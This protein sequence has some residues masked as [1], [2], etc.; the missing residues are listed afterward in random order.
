M[1]ET[2]PYPEHLARELAD[3]RRRLARAEADKARAEAALQQS[4]AR[5][6]AFLDNSP[7]VAL[8]KDPEGRLV[9]G[10]AGLDRLLS[11]KDREY[12][13][14][15]DDEL[16]PAEIAQRLR[17]N[18]ATVLAT[19]RPLET[20]EIVPNAE[21][22]LRSW[23]V[24]KFR[25]PDHSGDQYLGGVA[26]DITDWQR[27]DEKLRHN[28]ELQRRIL[29]AVPGGIVT[30]GL[31]RSICQANVEAQRILGLTWDQMS[32]RFVQDWEPET[33]WEDG[34]VCPAADYP[35]SRCLATGL[36]QPSTIIGVRQP[37]GQTSWAIYTA[38]PI[39]DPKSGDL[40][41]AVAT[42]LDITERLRAE[43]SQRESEEKFR[44]V[45]DNIREVFWLATADLSQTLYVSPAYEE[46]WGRSCASLYDDPASFLRA[47]HADDRERVLKSVSRSRIDGKLSHEYRIVRP[48]GSVRWVWDRGFPI[49]DRGGRIYRMAGIVEDITERKQ[50]EQELEQQNVVLHSILDSMAEG[51]V[52]ADE[53]GKLLLFNRAAEQIAGVGRVE[54]RPDQWAERYGLFLED[55]ATPLP[56]DQVP[57]S[58]AI[59]GEAIEEVDLYLKN[60]EVGEGRWINISGRPLRDKAGVHLGGVVVFRN[61][62][63]RHRAEEKLKHYAGQLQALSRRLLEVQEEERRYL[64]RELHDE[65]GQTLTGLKLMLERAAIQDLAERENVCIK[66]RKL[67]QELMVRVRGLYMRL[68]P[69]MLDDLGLMPA[70]RWQTQQYTEQTGVHVTM[71][72][73][74]LEACDRMPPEV[75]TTA[76]RIVQEALTNV[77]RHTQVSAVSVQI[78][79]EAGVLLLRVEDKGPG[80]TPGDLRES[81]GISGMQ[82]RATLLGG[83]LTVQSRPGDGTQIIAQLPIHGCP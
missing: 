16:F 56:A 50:A 10:N 52:V 59:G 37:G 75:E 76:Y 54:S 17:A 9:Y 70:L 81:S 4:E 44:Q 26:F 7:C 11:S 34:S 2:E 55:G 21:G 69:T 27:A 57:L 29:E 47:I 83:S 51:V 1:T 72:S 18:D 58:K 64:A 62:T 20:V 8:L 46:V 40:T 23:L 5:F 28:E 39:V 78:R 45:A 66:A 60:K 68:R 73:V 22:V 67:I 79:R 49:R 82:E 42:F 32:R 6:H 3:L 19:G 74:G 41:G 43:Q 61:V 65:V 31:D 33:L 30:V 36:P 13:G 15:T 80:F 77:A 53:N 25:V 24:I 14:K 48:D 38:V 35:V 71:A 12:L 63:E